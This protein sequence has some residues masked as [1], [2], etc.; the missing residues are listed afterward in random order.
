MLVSEFDFELPDNLIA[1]NPLAE[2]TD[3]KMLVLGKNSCLLDDEFANLPKYL[4]PGDVL[5]LND[6]EVIAARLYAKKTTGG[7]LEILIERILDDKTC[8]ALIKSSRAL[9]PGTFFFIADKIKAKIVSKNNEIYKLKFAIKDSIYSILRQYGH[10]PLPPYI[11][12][13][14]SKLDKTRYQTVYANNKGA[15]AAPTA[16]LHF[17]GNILNRI[18]EKGINIV[19]ITLHVGIG[20]FQP[21]RVDDTKEHKMHAEW[22]EVGQNAC[23]VINKAK[24]AGKQ[25]IAVGTTSLRALETAARSGKLKPYNGMTDIFITPGFDFKVVDVLLTNFHLPKSTLLMLI[26]A[27]A[28]IKEIKQAYQHAIDKKYRF[29]SYGDSTLLYKKDL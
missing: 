9:K 25:I 13:G 27:F 22:A 24:D 29:F 23:E 7:K 21:V 26:S 3:S 2:R 11:E 10:T 6:T 5:V 12:R 18:K 19:K 28:G 8:L 1:Q 4:N 20:T 16:G 15:V 17:D 14:D